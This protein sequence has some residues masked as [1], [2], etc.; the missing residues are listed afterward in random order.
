MIF[1]QFSSRLLSCFERCISFRCRHGMKDSGI[2]QSFIHLELKPEA[3]PPW[4]RIS[5]LGTIPIGLLSRATYFRY[6]TF[7]V[8]GFICFCCNGDDSICTKTIKVSIQFFSEF[9]IASSFIWRWWQYQLLILLMQ[10][11]LV[12][13]L[14]SLP[15][16]FQPQPDFLILD[17]CFTAFFSWFSNLFAWFPAKMTISKLSSR[18]HLFLREVLLYIAVFVWQ[19]QVFQ[20]FL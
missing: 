10:N 9:W 13:Q 5:E 2:F 17:F 15:R 7:C 3:I 6:G 4:E 14:E 19:I 18:F 16:I 8:T 12:F 1:S 11:K 20:S